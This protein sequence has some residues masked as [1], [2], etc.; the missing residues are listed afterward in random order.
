MY[1]TVLEKK[2]LLQGTATCTSTSS[3]EEE[4]TQLL[5]SVRWASFNYDQILLISRCR[6]LGRKILFLQISAGTPTSKL[7]YNSA[8][9]S[10]RT[11]FLNAAGPHVST[12]SIWTHSSQWSPR[13]TDSKICCSDW[14]DLVFLH[15][16]SKHRLISRSNLISSLTYYYF[17]C[18]T[19]I[20]R[21]PKFKRE[22]KW[23]RTP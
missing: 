5:R 14:P 17:P 13:Y 15:D 8:I 23:L 12:V 7:W 11:W 4:F 18:S 19:C 3:Q 22:A 9:N 16:F 6:N 1:C 2:T 10:L 20:A 21:I